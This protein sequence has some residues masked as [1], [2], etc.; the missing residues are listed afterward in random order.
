M[1]PHF[2]PY[3]LDGDA[4]NLKLPAPNSTQS[5]DLKRKAWIRFYVVR[6]RHVPLLGDVHATPYGIMVRIKCSKY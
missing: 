5:P 1:I 2:Q 6:I 3:I 4:R